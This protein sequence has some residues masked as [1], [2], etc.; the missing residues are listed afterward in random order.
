MLIVHKIVDGLRGTKKYGLIEI[1]GVT[2]AMRAAAARRIADAE[3]FDFGR[4]PLEPDPVVPGKW[5]LPALSSDEVSWW[6]AGLV[7]LPA[8]ACWFEFEMGGTRTGYLVR[9]EGEAWVI[10]RFDF[11][12]GGVVYDAI[13]KR[14][15]LADPGASADSIGTTVGGNAEAVKFFLELG[16]RGDLTAHDRAYLSAEQLAIDAPFVVYFA[17]MLNSRT[18]EKEPVRQSRSVLSVAR[19]RRGRSPLA[20]HLIVRIVPERYVSREPGAGG[21]THRSPRLHWRRSHLRHYDRPTPNSK[22]SETIEHEGRRG[23]HVAV[24]ARQLVGREDLGE[25]SHDYWVQPQPHKGEAR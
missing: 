17:L 1:P 9:D 23:W 8:P 16:R 7:P 21:G 3:K 18:T 2:P 20:D 13:E 4:P 5:I 14:T 19:T 11:T 15:A 6:R 24:I 10:E 25:I 22:W 12:A